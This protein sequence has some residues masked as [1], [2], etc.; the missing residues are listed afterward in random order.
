MRQP[1]IDPSICKQRRKLLAERSAGAAV[2]LPSTPEFIRNNDVHYDYRQDS[3]LFYLC[4]FEEP[5]SVLVFRAGQTPETVLFVRPKD[6]VRE[7]WD[8]FRFGPDLARDKFQVDECY[9][10][11]EIEKVLPDL[12]SSVDRVYYRLN[13]NNEFDSILAKTLESV[14]SK[15]GRTGMGIKPILDPTDLI[16][17]LRLIKSQAD[18]EWQ[19]KACEL[20]ADGHIAAMK[21]TKPGVNERQ[22][23]AVIRHTFMMGGSPRMGYGPIVATGDGATTL[24]YVFNDQTCRENELI[25]VDA[26]TEWNYFT[27]DI[28][29]TFPVSGRFSDSQKVFYSAVLDVQNQIISMIRPGLVFKNLQDTAIELLTEACIELGLLKMGKDEA[30]AKLEYK[31][32]YPHGVSHWLGMDVHDIGAYLLNGDSRPLIPGMIFTVEPGLYVP[33]SDTS[34]PAEFRGMGVRIE[35]DILVT[36][37]GH[38]NMTARAPKSIPDIEATMN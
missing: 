29:R 20:S 16:G 35:D 11:T 33:A 14:R 8:G 10:I 27:G 24:H 23:E 6:P 2:I 37:T 4:G 15:M 7:T 3:S 36:E 22:I 13:R 34:A 28:T 32:Y 19:K 31:K 25:L 5:E 1:L 12:V 17:E 26:G 38:L 18:I 9:L 21:A 30:I